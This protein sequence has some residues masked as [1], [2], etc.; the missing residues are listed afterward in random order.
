M[1]AVETESKENSREGSTSRVEVRR[2]GE[3]E[4]TNASSP[5]TTCA[6]EPLIR[7]SRSFLPANL[8]VYPDIQTSMLLISTSALTNTVKTCYYISLAEGIACHPLAQTYKLISLG[9]VQGEYGLP[10]THVRIIWSVS[11]TEAQESAGEE[12]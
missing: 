10:G 3:K 5:P 8:H 12:Y 11:V 4:G 1:Q 9:C 6:S 7:P 2:V